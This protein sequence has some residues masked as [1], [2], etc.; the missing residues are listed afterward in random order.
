MVL[1]IGMPLSKFMMSIAQI[2]MA[3]NWILEGNWKNKFISFY[4][5]KS[6]L[7][8]SSLLLLHFLG[9]IYT[10]NSHDAYLDIKVKFPL[11]VFPF[12]LSTLP[13]FSEKTV[14][15]ILRL[16]VGSVLGCTIFSTLLLF[17][18]VHRHIV[19]ARG[20]SI[21]ISHIRFGLLICVAIF[22]SGTFIG[23]ANSYYKKVG[24]GI[25]VV[26]FIVFLILG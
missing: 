9:L 8:L 6:A 24:W 26:W 13:P 5:N 3:A 4:K 2:I 12:L 18:I 19:D 23:K 21:F 20:I 10:S 17:G 15:T 11:F 25:I 7:A 14:N 1:V 16:F 22:I